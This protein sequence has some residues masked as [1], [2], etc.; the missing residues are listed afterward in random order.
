MSTNIPDPLSDKKVDILQTGQWWIVELDD[1]NI[2]AQGES[3]EEALDKLKKR[4]EQYWDR[5]NRDSEWTEQSNTRAI[6]ASDRDHI[7]T[8]R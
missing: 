6:R 4:L 2:A 1:P 7:T 8:K 3:K 5:R